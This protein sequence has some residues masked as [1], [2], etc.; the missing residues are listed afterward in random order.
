MYVSA[1]PI[2]VAIQNGGQ[3]WL[4]TL[5][6]KGTHDSICVTP[7]CENKLATYAQPRVWLGYCQLTRRRVWKLQ[8]DPRNPESA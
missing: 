6:D 3:Q 2:H 5:R 7:K 1:R 4:E 8:A